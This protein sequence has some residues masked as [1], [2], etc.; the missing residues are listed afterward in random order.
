MSA[1][2]RID[3]PLREPFLARDPVEVGR[4]PELA[5][6]LLQRRDQCGMGVAERRDRDTRAEVQIALALRI[7]QVGAFAAVERDVRPVVVRQ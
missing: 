7:E 6:L 1:K 5:R 4:V 3:Q 2:R